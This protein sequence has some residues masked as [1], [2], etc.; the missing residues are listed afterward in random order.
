MNSQRELIMAVLKLIFS[1][2]LM[3]YGI[4]CFV[5][6]VIDLVFGP[7]RDDLR[8]E[9]KTSNHRVPCRRVSAPASRKREAD[10]N[11]SQ[12]DGIDTSGMSRQDRELLSMLKSAQAGGN[13]SVTVSKPKHRNP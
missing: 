7:V 10:N 11:E 3:P 2:L 6:S 8:N 4:L 9:R 5:F 12:L 1:L 13:V